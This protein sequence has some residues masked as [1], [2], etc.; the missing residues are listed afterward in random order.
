[1]LPIF[2]NNQKYKNFCPRV[3][4]YLHILEGNFCLFECF[5]ANENICNQILKIIILIK[6]KFLFRK[7]NIKI[8]NFSKKIILNILNH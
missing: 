1:M 3:I 2:Y 7:L 4:V 8:N 6:T 5:R